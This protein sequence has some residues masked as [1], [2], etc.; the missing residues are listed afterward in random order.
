[1]TASDSQTYSTSTISN[2]RKPPGACTSATSPSCLPI[3]ARA[4]G[5][6][7]DND[8]S[9]YAAAATKAGRNPPVQPTQLAEYYR[10]FI[11]EK[12]R[13]RS[14]FDAVRFLER[15]F[16]PSPWRPVE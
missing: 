12:Q 10:A 11:D 15:E 9:D 6:V 5:E 8:A 3:N 7:T 14:S 2:S 13:R 4:I 1:M 16:P